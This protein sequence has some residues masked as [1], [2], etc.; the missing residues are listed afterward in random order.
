MDWH[1]WSGYG[2]LALLV[3]RIYWGFAG[4]STARFA[5]FLRGQLRL[6]CSEHQ[7]ASADQQSLNEAAADAAQ[8]FDVA[9]NWLYLLPRDVDS[10][11]A[12]GVEAYDILL[13]RG[14][15]CAHSSSALLQ[16]VRGEMPAAQMEKL[17]SDMDKI[18]LQLMVNL[19]GGYGDRLKRNVA[20]MKAKAL[21]VP[22]CRPCYPAPTRSPWWPTESATARRSKSAPIR[23]RR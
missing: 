17:I 6:W 18:N 1:R 4:T 9:A 2:V 11:Y 15:F 3:F 22:P 12:I 19:S 7:V 21:A 5:A 16:R 13:Q 23:A 8:A 14:H 10:G 20:A